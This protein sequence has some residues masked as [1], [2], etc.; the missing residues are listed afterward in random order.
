M[1]C[2]SQSKKEEGSVK[3]K[4]VQ[5]KRIYRGSPAIKAFE[6]HTQSE[7]V[8]RSSL[9]TVLDRASAS[10]RISRAR[11]SNMDRR[12]KKGCWGTTETSTS[13]VKQ[14]SGQINSV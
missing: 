4:A 12:K 14:T 3:V 9:H 2:Q 11:G 8:C 6:L 10:Y 13:Q 7:A 1:H 5:K